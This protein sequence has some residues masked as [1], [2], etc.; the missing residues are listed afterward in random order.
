MA[1]FGPRFATCAYSRSGGIHEQRG[2]E[3]PSR[4]TALLPTDG[5]PPEMLC[6]FAP[7]AFE[8]TWSVDVLP[9][10]A[11]ALIFSELPA[12]NASSAT[13]CSSAGLNVDFLAHCDAVGRAHP[14]HQFSVAIN[15]L[16]PS[17]WSRSLRYSV[18][19]SRSAFRKIPSSSTNDI[20]MNGRCTIAVLYLIRG[21]GI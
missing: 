4:C 10:P 12:R 21:D 20:E 15:I 9:V 19:F 5:I 11:N 8:R 7:V 16:K 18:S 1:F 2:Y 3:S 14:L 17:S 13:L 6:P